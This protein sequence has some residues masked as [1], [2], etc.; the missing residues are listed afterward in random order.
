MSAYV[1][2]V[3][4]CAAALEANGRKD[5]QPVMNSQCIPHRRTAAASRFL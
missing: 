2:F 1:V 5:E 4:R 3:I